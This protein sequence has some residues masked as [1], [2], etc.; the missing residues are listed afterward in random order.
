MTTE[1]LNFH[2]SKSPLGSVDDPIGVS[3]L[4][5]LIKSQ[6]EGQ[7]SDVALVG[8]IS[9]FKAHSSGHYY[10][11]LKD[12]KSVI[13]AVMFRGANSKL[14]FRPEDGMKVIGMGRISVYPPRGNYQIVLSRMEPD[15]QGSL[16]LAFEQLKKKLQEKGYFEKEHKKP[17]PKFPQKVAVVTAPTGAAIRDVLN[18]LDRRFAGLDILIY[19]VRVQ[20]TGSAEEVAL[21][22][23]HLNQFFPDI[24]A[25]IVGRGGGSLEDLWAF[26][27]EVV[28][29]AIYKSEI[30]I[31]S[32]VGHEVDF[33]IADFVADERA[34]TPSAAAEI[35]VS[36]KIE[37]IRHIDHLVRQLSQI[38]RRLELVYMR[39]DELTQRLQRSLIQSFSDLKIRLE[40]LRTRLS[41]KNPRVELERLRSRLSLVLNRLQRL[42]KE[43]LESKTYR[44][45]E[46]DTHLKLLNPRS[47]MERGY[48]IVRHEKSGKVIKK[49][50][51]VQMGESLLIE[52][53]KGKIRARV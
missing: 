13:S 37:T 28:A 8:E 33:T 31:I 47:I 7:F 24:D 39:V 5:Q 46:L 44:V 27:E 51:E 16:Q 43:I 22:I 49:A 21:A 36:N 53:H 42:P 15:G 38:E 32:A 6:L 52:L 17:I 10:F 34:P 19:P 29:N 14:K 18:V 25:M 41:E 11:A 20:G 9:N 4:T 30:P 48:S 3:D 12:E 35:V 45:K 2:A 1:S 26:N 40:A 23:R 50:S